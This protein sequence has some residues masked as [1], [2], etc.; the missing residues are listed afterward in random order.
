[1][2]L[3]IVELENN[4]FGIQT[5]DYW[6]DTVYMAKSNPHYVWKR[7]TD[8]FYRSCHFESISQ[9]LKY[10][11]KYYPKYKIVSEFELEV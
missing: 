11:R 8:D 4:T 5:K 2:I 7:E 6:G 9:I 3:N 10:I 1:M